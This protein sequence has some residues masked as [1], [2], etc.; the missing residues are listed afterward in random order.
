MRTWQKIAVIVVV[1]GVT[2]TFHYGWNPFGGEHSHVLHSIH[3]RLCYV[4]I[5]LAAGWFGLRGGV[6]G[7]L[8]ISLSVL[9]YIFTHPELGAHELTTEY[10][11]IIFYFGLGAL[12]GWLFDRQRFADFKRI[13]AERKLAQTERLG[14]LGRMVATV[15]HEIRNP[16][17]SIRGS[18]EILSDDIP[19][20]SPRHEFV[21]II[22]AETNRLDSIVNTYLEY[23]TPRKPRTVPGNLAAL[24]HDVV[25]DFPIPSAAIEI[26][27]DLPEKLEAEFDPDQIRRVLLN[28]LR[29]AFEAMPDTG[30]ITISGARSDHTATL[31]I[32]D[33]GPGI[34]PDL[35]AQLFQPFVSD[36]ASGSGLG[37]SLSREIVEAHGGRLELIPAHPPEA[38]AHFRITLPA[39]GQTENPA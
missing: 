16:L 38:G 6:L 33:T 11:E 30:T 22:Q 15:A 32:S 9:P 34:S 7:A 20:D 12:T 25:N 36:K 8:G 10:M 23:S 39:D 28:L 26:Q 2:L 21:N 27:T 37:L 17:G 1:A 24:V 13:Q 3:G 14:M 5:L 31:D 18:V 29:N 4:P 19:A 35:Q